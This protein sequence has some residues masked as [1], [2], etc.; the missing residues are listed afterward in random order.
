[1]VSVQAPKEF[2]LMQNYPNPFN[3][4]TTFAFELPTTTQVR[5]V[6]YNQKGQLVRKL[7]DHEMTAGFHTLVWDAKDAFGVQ[8][9]TGI[10]LYRMT[11]GDF[12]ETRKLTLMK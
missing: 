11:A 6:I 4:T 12:S 2:A 9:P 1:M 7:L 5:L 10:Y 8:V 3:P